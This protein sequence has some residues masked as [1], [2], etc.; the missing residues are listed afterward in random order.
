MLKHKIIFLILCFLTIISCDFF[1]SGNKGESPDHFQVYW[2]AHRGGGG[3]EMP[4]NTMASFQY[5]WK[6]GG[7]PE[8][9]LRTTKDSIIVCLHD[10]TPA[11]TTTAPASVCDR[12]IRTF[13][14]AETR[15][16]DAGVKFS[17]NFRGQV[18]PTLREVFAEMK[19]R[20]D[21]YIY[22]DLKHV[23][24]E[25][26]GHMID[27][28]DIGNQII[29]ASPKQ[30]ECLELKKI[31][32]HVHTMLWIGGSAEAIKKKFYAAADSDFDGLDQVQL[33]LNDKKETSHWRY[34]LEPDF[35]KEALNI[36]HEARI[37]LEVFPWKFDQEN[38][39][40]LLNM[41][42]RWY[43]TDEPQRFSQTVAMW[44]KKQ[45]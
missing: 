12:D 9:D 1:K 33:H 20:P 40:D 17:G 45:R 13:Q 14:F 18:I 27:E 7:I 44:Q 16:W 15:K 22:L 30:H 10:P 34:E 39:H 21:R 35:L 23:D 41:G 32:R 37:D 38:L 2:Q 29:I 3:H 36:T 26:L 5:G 28:Y 6:L 4:D 11:R 8:A 19:G 43:A 25:R 24:L 31:A 42:I